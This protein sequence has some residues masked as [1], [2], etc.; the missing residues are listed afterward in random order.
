[1]PLE[2]VV[3][4]P[5]SLEGFTAELQDSFKTGVAATASVG[6]DCAIIKTDVIIS[7][8][9]TAAAPGTRRRLLA[10]TSI[11]VG[12]SILVPDVEKGNLLLRSNSL[13]LKSI[14]D[15]LEELGLEPITA[16]TSEPLLVGAGSS[17]GDG[18]Q[19][20]G[21]GIIDEEDTNL[22]VILG[23]SLNLAIVFG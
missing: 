15:E 3:V 12:V 8:K 2:F 7:I 11:A 22:G 9:E 23:I 19:T 17:T 10:A 16:I 1:M 18:N 14:N 4:L 13:S 5:Y 6:C 21:E 20:A